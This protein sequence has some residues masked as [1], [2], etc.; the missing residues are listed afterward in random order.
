MSA[1]ASPR[2]RPRVRVSPRPGSERPFSSVKV[3]LEGAS[4][5]KAADYFGELVGTVPSHLYHTMAYARVARTT[6]AY[7]YDYGYDYN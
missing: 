2:P 5:V 7:D 4:F 1:P 6:M 3:T